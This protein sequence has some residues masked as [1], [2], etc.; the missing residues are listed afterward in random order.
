MHGLCAHGAVPST[1]PVEA[2]TKVADTGTNLGG[3]GPPAGPAACAP[4]VGLV[5]AAPGA[6][7]GAFVAEDEDE[8]GLRAVLVGGCADCCADDAGAGCA[9]PALPLLVHAAAPHV[10]TPATTNHQALTMI[11]TRT[12]Y[13][14]LARPPPMSGSSARWP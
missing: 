9:V 5:L 2:A 6:G 3:T 8:C 7:A 11:V 13:P 10:A 12:V 14:H 4:C 1:H